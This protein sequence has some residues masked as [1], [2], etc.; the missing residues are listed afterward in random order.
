MEPIKIS[1]AKDFSKAVLVVTHDHRIFDCADRV[2]TIE[3]GKIIEDD[4]T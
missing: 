2:V 1:V 4:P 3:D